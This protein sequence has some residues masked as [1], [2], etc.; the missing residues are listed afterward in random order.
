[1]VGAGPP[2]TTPEAAAHRPESVEIA[3]AARKQVRGP[4][5]G[6]VW[7]ALLNW[8]AVFAGLAVLLFLDR[9]RVAEIGVILLAVFITLALGSGLM[10]FGALKMMRLDSRRWALFSTILAMIVGPGYVLGWPIGI[11]SLAVLTRPEVRRAFQGRAA[12]I[13]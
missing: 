1:M 11:W 4:A 3:E 12:V 10:L 6:L 5:L 2:P 9:A 7:T 13:A 8:V